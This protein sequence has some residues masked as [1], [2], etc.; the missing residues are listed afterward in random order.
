MKGLMSNNLRIIIVVSNFLM[1][2]VFHCQDR[3]LYLKLIYYDIQI[4]FI[5]KYAYFKMNKNYFKFKFK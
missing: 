3:Y 4:Y 1:F 5:Y 2:K